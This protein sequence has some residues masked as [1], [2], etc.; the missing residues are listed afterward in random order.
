MPLAAKTQ[1]DKP[2]LAEAGV[3]ENRAIR[4]NQTGKFIRELRLWTELL[5]SLFRPKKET[6]AVLR[7]RSYRRD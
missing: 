5:C 1:V 3:D 6:Q 4:D 2:T 7:T